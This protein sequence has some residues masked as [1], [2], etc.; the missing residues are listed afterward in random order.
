MKLLKLRLKNVNSFRQE[1]TLDFE[2]SPM[3]DSSLLAITGPTGSGKTTLLDALCVALYNKTPR[4][5]S[6]GNQNPGNLLSQGKTEAFA[7]VLFEADS[8]RYLAEWHVRRSRKGE[9]KPDAKLIYADTE[10]VITNR[11]T[12]RSKS[13]DIHEM[14]VS[15]AVTKILGLEFDAFNRSV[16]LAQGQFAAFLKAKAEERRTILEAT[17]GIAIYDTLKKTLNEKL[18]AVKQEYEQVEATLKAIPE[19]NEEEIN[20]VH[21]QLEELEAESRSL[22]Q[23]R[24]E[25]MEQKDA[26]SQRGRTFEQLVKAE[27][28]QTKL[29]SQGAEI[30]E[31]QSELDAARR[32][33]D[34][35][36]ERQT[37]EGEREAFKAA[38]MPLAEA[39][40]ELNEVQS[41]YDENQRRFV[42]IE[43]QYR[44]A[45]T[46]RN[47]RI[48][49]FNQARDEEIR[50]QTQFDEVEKR[51]DELK[52][53]EET[54]DQLTKTL[55]AQQE[56]KAGSEEQI[57][58]DRTFLDEN[59]IPADSD[60]RLI[61]GKTALVTLDGRTKSYREKLTMQE[62]LQAKSAQ[63]EDKFSNLEGEQGKL[64]EEKLTVDAAITQRE[65]ELN[66]LLDDGDEEKWG[67][68]K[69]EAQRLQ[70]IAREYEEAV[71]G[72]A[73]GEKESEHILEVLNS[74]EIDLANLNQALESQAKDVA[75]AE[76]KVKRY[77]AEEKGALMANH[78]IALRGD[79]HA[80]QPC[81]V[82]GATEHPWAEKEELGDE[83]QIELAQHNLAQ[84]KG[85]LQVQQ[86]KISDLQKRH[87]RAEANKADLDDRLTTFSKTVETSEAAIAS[88]Q[89]QW[90]ESF[91]EAE[92]SSQMIQ[93]MV[94]EADAHIQD[95]HKARTAHTDALNQQQLIE[96]RLNSHERETESVK[97]QLEEIEGQR[98]PIEGNIAV[99]NDEIQSTEAQFW[100][101]LPNVLHGEKP[102][103]A[104]NQFEE[105]MNAVRACEKR[106]SEKETQLNRLNADLEGYIKQLESEARRKAEIEG[107]I[108]DYQAE[109]ERLSAS[110][111]EKT[112]GLRAE[113]AIQKLEAELQGTAEQRDLAQSAWRE[114]GNL[115]IRA[116]SK[117][118]HANSQS[119]ASREKFSTAQQ[120]YL[121][122]LKNAEFA[123]PEEHEAAFRDE[124]W[125][126]TSEAQLHKYRS[127]LR[128]TEAEVAEHRAIFAD[129]QFDPETIERLQHAEQEIDDQIDAIAQEIGS[130][131]E[132]Q[133]KLQENLE[134]ME[135]QARVVEEAH[136]EKER[137][138]RLQGCI[139]ENS[140]RDFA[141]ERMFDLMIRLANKQLDDLTGRYKLRVQGMRDMVVI[142]RWNAN[143]ERPVETL[144]GGESF[145]T[146]LSLALAL[147]EMSRG[148]TQ[149]NSL[150]LDEGFGTLDSQTLDVA[151]SALE[152]LQ[153]RG[154]SIV[155]ISHVG[156]LTRRIPVRIA[157]E[158]MG[159]GSSRV[160]VL[161]R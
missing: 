65:A 19:T 11:L 49:A 59:P 87:A 15:G 92:I 113:E 124:S 54:I 130:L 104:L 123:S 32:A 114:T 43:A 37:F 120:T 36:L 85:A 67:H 80:G 63:L 105:Q 44:L 29:L 83:S 74:V 66:A 101:A 133:R 147:S 156:E 159:N 4:L 155:V 151:I 117:L 141:L 111:F 62:E 158:K 14:S 148:R 110:A 135:A 81:R 21:T 2:K 129:A 72:L 45:E 99:L 38:D 107:G 41:D 152:G 146:S 102:E 25:I 52:T 82:C 134:R 40:R 69:Q 73:E 118:D 128:A 34:L 125:V 115:L 50:A 90:G 140:L 112:G 9:L 138:E 75:L 93:G 132:Q 160:R 126:E 78:I 56:E 6:T 12:S 35:R 58:S 23:Q 88:A 86:E 91:P 150:F 18:S 95:L 53:V 57:E 39:Q 5:S 77:E 51:R 84:A 100:E 127:D 28:R 48:E 106:L 55:G 149:L 30:D 46:E 154:R 16:M 143:E 137:W 70:P 142:D 60:Q 161:G 131:R 79:L 96:Q 8:T 22:Q 139:P 94:N 122:A 116:Q 20:R 103:D 76:E 13:D 108:A 97:A 98:G 27:A 42:E 7:E 157:V 3:T 119:E 10:E 61:G 71:D 68:Q 121:A 89:A 1:I 144:S 47:T 145:L 64:T 109:G 26:E 153:L 17:T 136:Q 31:L 24:R 33:A